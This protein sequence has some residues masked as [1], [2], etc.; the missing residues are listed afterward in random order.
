MKRALRHRN[1]EA[2]RDFVASGIERASKIV[3]GDG[4][5]YHRRGVTTTRNGGVREIRFAAGAEIF[6]DSSLFCFSCAGMNR[7][8]TASRTW[9]N[10]PICD[11]GG[12]I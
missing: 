2:S 1:F 8:F 7:G 6:L 10:F 12:K 3:C 9:H 4:G 5:K 11:R